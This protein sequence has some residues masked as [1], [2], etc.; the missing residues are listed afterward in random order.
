MSEFFFFILGIIITVPLSI[1]ANLIT[2]RIKAMLDQRTL[3]VRFKKVEDLRQEK[4]RISKKAQSLQFVYL[5]AL[6]IVLL[7]LGII[8][9]VLALLLIFQSL[10]YLSPTLYTRAGISLLAAIL[11]ASLSVSLIVAM[12]R[13][14]QHADDLQRIRDLSK[15][16][17]EIDTQIAQLEAQEST[18]QTTD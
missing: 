6:R 17:A 8:V 7:I 12:P 18:Q 3:R 13:I 1:Y 2:P 16:L 14:Q 5:D 11:F 10:Q 9:G 4:E 15:Y